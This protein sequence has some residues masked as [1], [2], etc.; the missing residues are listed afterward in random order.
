MLV[1]TQDASF[2]S[3]KLGGDRVKA[4]GADSDAASAPST[5]KEKAAFQKYEAAAS[6]EPDHFSAAIQHKVVS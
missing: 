4:G 1:L 6:I 3:S 5:P 2:T